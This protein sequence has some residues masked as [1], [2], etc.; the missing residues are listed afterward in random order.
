MSKRNLKDNNMRASYIETGK[1][2]VTG[3]VRGNM[4]RREVVERMSASKEGK[5]VGRSQAVVGDMQRSGFGVM[6]GQVGQSQMLENSQS[7]SL[8]QPIRNRSSLIM[9]PTS[10]QPIM[11]S[12]NRLIM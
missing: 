6:Q 3:S 12:S 5:M 10:S 2:G 1:L 4:T 7:L 8:T 9:T 11:K